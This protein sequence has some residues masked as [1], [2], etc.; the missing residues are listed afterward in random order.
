[1]HRVFIPLFVCVLLITGVGA[2]QSPVMAQAPYTP[3]IEWADCPFPVPEGETPG[4][5]LD[6]GYLSVPQDRQSP[7]GAQIALAV[8][9]LYSTAAEPAPDPIVYLEGGPGGSAISG[10][11]GWLDFPMRATRDII[12]IDQ[13]G[14]G[15]SYPRLHC[16]EIDELD[17][18][19]IDAP[20]DTLTAA[21]TDALQ[22]CILRLWA[23]SAV[24]LN[25]YNSAHSAADIADLRIALGV[26]QVNLFGISYG[27]RLALTVMRDYPAGVRSVILDS[28]YPPVVDAYEEMGLNAHRSFQQMFGD[29]AADPACNAAYPDL[30]A[31]FYRLVEAWNNNPV[32]IGVLGA[33]FSGDDVVDLMFDYFYNT[34]IV[35]YLPLMIHELEAGDYTTF[36]ALYDGY[37]PDEQRVQFFVDEFYWLMA[38]LD[39]DAYYAMWDELDYWAFDDWPALRRIIETYFDVETVTFLH[40]VLDDMTP[41]ELDALNVALFDDDLVWLFTDE[42]LWLWDGLDDAGYNALWDDMYA[43]EPGDWMG[44][45]AIIERHFARDDA[46]YL[47]LLLDEMTRYD[48]DRLAIDLQWVII[49]DVA[50]TDG[51][52]NAVECFEEV[53]FNTLADTQALAQAL[54]APFGEPYVDV[55]ELQLATCAVWQ[56]GAAGMVEDAA[57]V[58]AIPTLV[59]AGNYDPI[60]PPEW[61]RITAETLSNGQFF[62]FPGV[63]HGVIDGGDCPLRMIEAFLDEPTI[64]VDSGCLAAMTGPAFVLP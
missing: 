36:V 52:H 53:P 19:V 3:V 43:W 56:T 38:E 45:R 11:E 15:F 5:T 2:W 64:P 13:R 54:P 7:D 10:I 55:F 24:N 62:T 6:C 32:W 63:G 26:E 17:W 46:D 21:E 20:D 34:F 4:T 30:G 39:D 8:V 51:L 61:G 42:F 18:D 29:C 27:T 48:F 60:T 9:V 44:L 12:L 28:A 41:Q 35:P 37:L 59:L 58:S 31:R 57:V 14:T 50:N 16:W 23:E 47:L 40:G 49:E 22:A 33:E 1:M 25:F